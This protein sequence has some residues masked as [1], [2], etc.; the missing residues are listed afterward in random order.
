[1]I[2]R[3]EVIL[4]SPDVDRLE[5]IEA[6]EESEMKLRAGLSVDLKGYEIVRVKRLYGFINPTKEWFSTQEASEYTG[7]HRSTLLRFVEAGELQ[8]SADSAGEPRYRKAELDS[9]LEGKGKTQK[10]KAA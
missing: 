7:W 3:Y 8:R 6:S 5:T 4:R 10:R 2:S 9:L 1:V